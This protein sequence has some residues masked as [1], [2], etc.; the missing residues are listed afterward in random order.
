LA[1]L[2]GV[3]LACLIVGRPAGAAPS[4]VHP[5][6][7]HPSA[8][9]P[10]GVHPSGIR[11]FGCAAA[12]A[13]TVS[14][15][16]QLV[17]GLGSL[18]PAIT[19][20]PVGY[21]PRD[22]QA[23][24]GLSGANARGRL[25]AVVDAFDDPKAAADLA[26]YRRTYGLP[27]CTSA[28]GCFRKVNGNGNARPLPARDYGWAT[29]IS[30]DLDAVSAACPSCHILLVEAAGPVP[31]AL[32][33]GVDTAVRLGA[34]AVGN[35]WGGTESRPVVALDPHMRHP[36]VAITVASG[37]RGFQ[38]AWPASSPYV[39][40]VGGT[41]L[42]R[43]SNSRGWTETAWSGSGSGCSQYEPKP[44]WQHDTGCRRRTVA[45]VAA[46][47]DPTTG[48]GIYDT[49]NNCLLSVL[50]DAQIAAGHAEGLDGWAKAGGTSL[51]APLIAA[52]YALAGNREA[53]PYAYAHAG[54]LNDV[55]SGSNGSC[56]GS[57]LCTARRG[58][59]GP[60][61]LGTPHGLGAF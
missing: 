7:V 30:L 23:A 8:V 32:A 29:E 43:A 57:Y 1:C 49:F 41:S 59:D 44:S 3:A 4:G 16:G 46:D 25:V 13:G 5:S 54:S 26:V 36:G 9:H 52:V 60:T 50:C 11:P 14:C 21:G 47:A 12:R 10:S 45:D 2:L 48:L 35:S 55:R 39:T 28:N 40:S 18:A 61:G 6:A 38:V 27:P 53:A 17:V 19:P 34:V 24:Y 51:A 15:F 37:D 58:Y 56:G 22:I 33:A 42:R 31:D 20:G